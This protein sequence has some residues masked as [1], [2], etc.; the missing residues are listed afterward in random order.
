MSISII[1]PAFNEENYIAGTLDH[2]NQ[3]VAYLRDKDDRPVEIIV[4][5]NNSG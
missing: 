4:V 3:A 5:D 2:I 1:I